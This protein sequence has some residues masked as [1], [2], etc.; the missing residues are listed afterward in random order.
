MLFTTKTTYILVFLIFQVLCLQAQPVKLYQQFADSEIKRFPEAWQLDHGKR[1]YF[2]YAQG[3]GCLAMLKL[4]EKTTDQRY[5]DYVEAWAD[6]IINENG[7]IHLYKIEAYNIDY[8]NPAKILFTLYDKTGKA[9]Y[10]RAIEKLMGQLKHHPRTLEGVYWHKLIYPHQIWLDGIYMGDPFVAAYGKF[11]NDSTYFDDVL[12]QILV[13]AKH[14]RDKKTGLYYHAWDESRKQQWANKET[15][16][17]PN[18]WGR[19]VGWWFMALVDVLDFIPADYPKRDSVTT[20]LADL[21]D[22][23]PRYQDEEGLWWQ[24]LDKPHADG[25]YQEASVNAMFM[26]AYAK[27][28]NKGYIAK[29]YKRIAEKTWS[30]IERKLLKREADGSL[31]LMQCNA[32]AGLGGHPYRD[33]SYGYY[34]NER[35]RE[36]DSKATGPLI[37]G[38]LELDK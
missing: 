27:A 1:L 7:D 14:T 34:V 29:K 22:T 2:G 9:K 3:L 26:Y 21:A 37:M 6:T 33:G 15:G 4:W 13:T 23:L 16:Q 36:N 5:F 10:Q 19:S 18:F 35:V 38:L 17:S 8:I 12:N 32:V 31:T 24:V 11:V 30:G 25:N 28:V 20:L